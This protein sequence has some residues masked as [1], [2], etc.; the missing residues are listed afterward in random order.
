MKKLSD[1]KLK[2]LNYKELNQYKS[3][4]NGIRIWKLYLL[5]KYLERF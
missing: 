4:I 3:R 5:E 2:E 1:E